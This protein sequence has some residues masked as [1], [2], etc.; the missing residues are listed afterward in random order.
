MGSYM[1]M[2]S[3]SVYRR[4]LFIP[5]SNELE[6][7]TA[8]PGHA[9]QKTPPCVCARVRACV[10]GRERET[11]RGSEREREEE[12]EDAEG[13]SSV[14]PLMVRAQELKCMRLIA[15]ERGTVCARNS[16]HP[17]PPPPPP[18]PASP[19]RM[20][21]F[22]EGC[23]KEKEEEKKRKKERIRRRITKTSSLLFFS[24]FFFFFF[25][26]SK[27]QLCEVASFG[28]CP[29]PSPTHHPPPLLSRIGPFKLRPARCD[30]LASLSPR[31]RR[32]TARK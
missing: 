30:P 31:S 32:H 12:R 19:A 21:L 3:L 23:K 25:L 27:K 6:A 11:E 24:F 17:P 1:Q 7:V 15:C 2:N 20:R 18:P 14:V 5:A 9:C 26:H 8:G 28:A 16:S 29:L 4:L 10:C 22:Q 13:R